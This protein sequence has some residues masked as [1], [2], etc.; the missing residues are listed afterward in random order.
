MVGLTQDLPQQE[1]LG[2]TGSLAD[3]DGHRVGREGHDE[4]AEAQGQPPEAYSYLGGQEHEG[5]CHWDDEDRGLF[6]EDGE[7]RGEGG[8]VE[9]P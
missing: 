6:G 7:A 4:Q 2:G 3:H 8:S 9:P 1:R 5:D